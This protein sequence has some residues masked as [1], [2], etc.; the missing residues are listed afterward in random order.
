[1][2]VIRRQA[3]QVHPVPD[4]IMEP[5]GHFPKELFREQRIV[6]DYQPAYGEDGADVPVGGTV[7]NNYERVMRC[8]RCF[9]KVLQS[10]TKDHICK[11]VDEDAEEVQEL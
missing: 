11:D 1:M 5:Q 7:Q 2:K 8:S 4:R 6:T 3:V 9:E 10:E